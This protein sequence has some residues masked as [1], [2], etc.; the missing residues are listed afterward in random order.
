MKC[1]EC[2]NDLQ[3][4]IQ[5]CPYCGTS[6]VS[7]GYSARDEFKWNVQDFP[8]PHKKEDISIDWKTGKLIDRASNKIFD[9]DLNIW[10]DFNDNDRLMFDDAHRNYDFNEKVIQKKQFNAPVFDF[11]SVSSNDDFKPAGNYDK[12]EHKSLKLS[13]D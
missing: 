9:T 13:D 11:S 4:G 12:K 3:T 6:A 2:G 10:K 7:A 5:V 8:K 1:K